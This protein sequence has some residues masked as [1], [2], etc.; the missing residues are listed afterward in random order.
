MREVFRLLMAAVPDPP[1]LTSRPG[2][3]KA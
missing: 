3:D 1:D 2:P